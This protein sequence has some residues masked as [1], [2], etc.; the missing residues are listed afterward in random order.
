MDSAPKKTF[1]WQWVAIALLLVI[2]IVLVFQ[3]CVLLKSNRGVVIDEEENKEP[4]ST[5]TTE[6]DNKLDGVLYYENEE[7]IYAFDL[8]SG[9]TRKIVDGSRPT[10]SSDKTKLAY[11]RYSPNSR[12]EDEVYY[13]DLTTNSKVLFVKFNEKDFMPNATIESWSPD[14]K[15]VIIDSGT[16]PGR[17]KSV[18]SFPGAIEK[19]GFPAHGLPSWIDNDT[20]VFTEGDFHLARETD[21]SGFGVSIVSTDGKLTRL[22]TPTLLTDYS[23]LHAEGETIYFQKSSVKTFSDWGKE[24][25]EETYWS[26]SRDGQN[27]Q[28][29]NEDQARGDLDSLN[30]KIKSLLPPQYRDNEFCYISSVA[31]TSKSN[32][33]IFE[34]YDGRPDQYN[35]YIAKIDLDKPESFE[36]LFPGAWPILVAK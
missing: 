2:I 8:G 36:I 13:Y 35:G 23:V 1:P 17:F 27:E 16:G 9:Q 34:L 14:G 21:A 31:K 20:V 28:Q 11:V 24:K 4:A 5:V 32:T 30:N 7:Q 26:I 18:H 6:L 33:V 3:Y 22:K 15:H 19:A 12:L 29:V 10:L 25:I